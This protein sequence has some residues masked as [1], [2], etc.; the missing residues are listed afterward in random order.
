MVIKAINSYFKNEIHIDRRGNIYFLGSKKM[1]LIDAN[2]SISYHFNDKQFILKI[3]KKIFENL[4]GAIISEKK[5]IL[6]SKTRSSNNIIQLQ[7][8]HRY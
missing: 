2:S 6:N 7:Y 3:D 8:E 4:T 1:T 5:E